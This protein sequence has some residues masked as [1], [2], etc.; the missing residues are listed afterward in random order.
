MS[1]LQ[2]SCKRTNESNAKLSRDF[3]L[4]T[5]AR[6]NISLV[7]GEGVYV[8]DADGKK[9]LDLFAG[10]AVDN[11]GHCHPQIQKVI[12]NQVS[13]LMHVSNVFVIQE[14]AE[15][16][17]KLVRLS[18]LDKAF[19]C[20]SG[21]EAN[22]AAIK[23]AR[24]YSI[25]TTGDEERYE[26]ISCTNS[27]HGRTLGALSATAQ[28]VYQKGFGPLVPGFKTATFGDFESIK[29]Q[30]T[31]KTCAILVEP[32]QGEGGV[33]VPPDNFFKKL[34]VLCDEKNILLI[35]DEVQTGM[36]RTG[37]LFGHQHYEIL[38]DLMPL[39]KALGSGF[40]V[41]ACL[42][43]KK[44]ADS[45]VPGIHASTFGGNPLASR[46]ALESL[47]IISEPKFLSHVNDVG[48][49]FL[50]GLQKLKAK[51]GCIKEARGMGLMLGLEFNDLRTDS[52]AKLAQEDGLLINSIKNK[53]LRF[54]PPLIL[55]R[56][57]VDTALQIIDKAISHSVVSV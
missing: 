29:A 51:H 3:V 50:D 44:I 54:V 26:I 48:N 57:H 34:R 45:V 39:S 12:T 20:N 21:T 14:Q 53:V 56:Q 18:G 5:Y 36:G 42:V 28:S 22:E 19:F 10:V 46:V 25:K 6:K 49:Y 32:I 2:D 43:A 13:R 41:G 35:L 52:I 40:P 55:E 11:L 33:N 38:P 37:K 8:W 15:L 31:D 17:E 4:G 24:Y 7:F 23:L 1:D 30:V 16:A 9:Y 47:N 27:F